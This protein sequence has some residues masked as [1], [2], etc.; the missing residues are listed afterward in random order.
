MI[1]FCKLGVVFICYLMNLL[2]AGYYGVEG[3]ATKCIEIPTPPNWS[4][5]K[6]RPIFREVDTRQSGQSANY[7]KS[8][9]FIFLGRNIL[10]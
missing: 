10:Q 7:I 8:Q 6:E 1:L 3:S 9:Q 2:N 4:C 5:G